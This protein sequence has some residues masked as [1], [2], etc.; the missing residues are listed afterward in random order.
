MDMLLGW[1]EVAMKRMAEE[2]V[3]RELIDNTNKAYDVDPSLVSAAT[4]SSTTPSSSITA[5]VPTLSSTDGGPWS[6]E[7]ALTEAAVR[8]EI[9]SAV[10][11]ST[12]EEMDDASVA[13]PAA[14]LESSET[15]EEVTGNSRLEKENN[16][17]E[18]KTREVQDEINRLKFELKSATSSLSSS[19][20]SLPS[21]I[22]IEAVEVD[23][24]L[25][26]RNNQQLD[27]ALDSS[28]DTS[29]LDDLNSDT[30]SSSPPLSETT[31]V[32]ELLNKGKR[33]QKK[34]PIIN[35]VVGKLHD[36]LAE[37]VDTW[38]DLEDKTKIHRQE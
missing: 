16:E 33:R 8:S 35:L 2:A 34:G 15:S 32:N 29:I 1:R 12:K 20:S 27:N 31:F 10:A 17:L 23:S 25:T 26:S 4:S 21:P 6:T 28:I 19:P 9:D 24:L 7:P 5:V 37:M 38:N 18:S 11:A 36:D 3:D 22:D 30:S 13:I 14:L